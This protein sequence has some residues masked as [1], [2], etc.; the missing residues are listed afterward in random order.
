MGNFK[1]LINKPKI[2]WIAFIMS[3]GFN[4]YLCIAYQSKIDYTETNELTEDDGVVTGSS[5]TILNKIEED[6]IKDLEKYPKFKK[7]ISHY[8]KREY[9]NAIAELQ[10]LVKINDFYGN[11]FRG[12]LYQ[13]MKVHNRSKSILKKGIEA[14]DK[15]KA[16][17]FY[18]ECLCR[19]ASQ[20]LLDYA[21]FSKKESL[22]MFKEYTQ[23]AK[24]YLVN[25]FSN[26][27][28]SDNRLEVILAAYYL[29]NKEYKN[30]FKYLPWIISHKKVYRD[31]KWVYNFIGFRLLQAEYF[32]EAKRILEY[33]VKVEPKSEVAHNS[34]GLAYKALGNYKRAKVHFE[35]SVELDRTYSLARENL[36]FLKKVME[37]RATQTK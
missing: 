21:T 35:K 20:N 16:S 27:S 28:V 37:Q 36:L 22:I 6:S 26:R 7:S 11:C 4:I 32:E 19:Y 30:L 1:L 8:Q 14:G 29:I 10:D 15:G 33:A 13:L 9:Q 17:Y 34:L 31:M 18:L 23:K 3:L 12:S 25:N 2:A 5:I 24:D